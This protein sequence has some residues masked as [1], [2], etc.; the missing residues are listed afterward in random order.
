VALAAGLTGVVVNPSQ[1]LAAATVNHFS[2]VQHFDAGCGFPATTE[3][4]TGTEHLIV[5]EL[6]NGTFH[7][8]YGETF[9]VLQVADDPDIAPFER[10][11]Q[12]RSPST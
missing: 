12:T 2:H 11:A 5:Q 7:V 6:P 3:Y 4:S 10:Q 1:A 8:T 9:T